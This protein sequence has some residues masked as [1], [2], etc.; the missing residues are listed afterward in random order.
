MLICHVAEAPAARYG[1]RM[2]TINLADIPLADLPALPPDLLRGIL[3]RA[4]PEDEDGAVPVA[5]FQSSIL[6]GSCD[7]ARL[8]RLSSQM[9]RRTPV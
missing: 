2:S 6:T 1:A 9:P 3:R 7:A 8:R 4:V 5:A